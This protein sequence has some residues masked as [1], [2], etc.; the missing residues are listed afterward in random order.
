MPGLQGE[1]A[2]IFNGMLVHSIVAE[3]ITKQK[4]VCVSAGFMKLDQQ[5]DEVSVQVFGSS[6]S[7]KLENRGL[8]DQVIILNTL[9]GNCG[10]F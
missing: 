10:Y 1:R 9:A 3:S 7:M 2:I 4:G 8:Q 5:D 6:E